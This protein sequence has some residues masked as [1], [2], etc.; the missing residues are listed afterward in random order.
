[1][2][3]ETIKTL[4]DKQMIPGLSGVI[5][6]LFPPLEA[7]KISEAQKKAG[8]HPQNLE[9][10]DDTG[11]IRVT[12]LRKT[13]HLPPSARGQKFSFQ[14]GQND[15][16]TPT[17]LTLNLYKDT[18]SVAVGGGA[19]IT[20]LDSAAP[21]AAPAKEAPKPQQQQRPTINNAES[22]AVKHVHTLMTLVGLS[23]NQLRGMSQ[24]PE[25]TL[26]DIAARLGTTIY[27]Q[28]GHKNLITPE[29][30]GAPDQV[31]AKS[32]VNGA[33]VLKSAAE[34]VA[35]FTVTFTSDDANKII[36]WVET[37]ELFTWK[38]LY[39]AVRSIESEKAHP[40]IDAQ[41]I[42]SQAN[43]MKANKKNNANDIYKIVCLDWENFMH[44]ARNRE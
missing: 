24:A 7:E 11:V 43:L 38:E 17:G 13:L 20:R 36:N 10:T 29:L 3:I 35:G 5:T 42:E 37:L 2:N 31:P 1:M 33:S 19:S 27:I 4:K 30:L 14:S 44:E 9:V 41:L 39:E 16:G 26:V 40:K 6:K 12:I 23:L 21:L 15:D 22:D 25:A 32:E 18:P 28:H 8:I 34:L